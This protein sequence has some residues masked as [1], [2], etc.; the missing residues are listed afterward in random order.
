MLRHDGKPALGGDVT[1]ALSVDSRLDVEPLFQRVWRQIFEFERQFSR[2]LPDSELSQFNRAA[3]VRQVITEDFAK[4]LI[5]SQSLSRATDGLYNPFILPAV[6]R[7][8]YL[9]SAV[10]GYTTDTTDDF[11]GRSVVPADSLRLE[12]DRHAT[13]P[14]GTALDM[15]GCGKGYLADA[16]ADE[17]D[18]ADLQGYWVALSGD[19]VTCGYDAEGQPWQT[20][21]VSA[22]TPHAD[23]PLR[24]AGNGQRLHIATS[25]TFQRPGQT[26]LRGHHIIDPRTGQAAQTDIKLATVVASRAIEADVL[27]SCAVIVGSQQATPYL[28]TKGALAAVIQ[29]AQRDR[30]YG[31]FVQKR[32]SLET[33][34]A[35]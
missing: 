20:S 8:G 4:L 25:G 7:A 30:S 23:S 1:L 6:Q 11:R 28:K 9:H 27:A 17:L 35:G 26:K 34:H 14:Y 5:A 19:M 24:V 3:G 12:A 15:G 16:I 31:T 32:L 18:H 13:I 10:T 2:F 29:T 22:R 21:I 33:V